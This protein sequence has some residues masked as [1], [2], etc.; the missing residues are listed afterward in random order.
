MAKITNTRNLS[1]TVAKALAYDDYS[2]GD[3]D[4]TVTGL[5]NPKQYTVLRKQ[6]DEEIVKDVADLAFSAFGSALHTL[7]ENAAQPWVNHLKKLFNDKLA[8]GDYTVDQDFIEQLEALLLRADDFQR[9]T[10]IRAEER[11]FAKI[12]VDGK[13]YVISGQFD[14]VEGTRLS[15]HKVVPI[16]DA[17]F[18]NSYE[19]YQ[20]QLSMLV[21]IAKQN[22]IEI[23]ETY[24]NAFYRD[25]HLAKYEEDL[26]RS[27]SG[28]TKHPSAPTANIKFDIL[29]DKLI[30]EYIRE[31]I[32]YFESDTVPPCT[33]E[34]VWK[35]EDTWKVFNKPNLKRATRNFNDQ[36]EADAFL[37]AQRPK[38]KDAYIEFHPGQRKRCKNYCDAAPFCEQYQ[39]WLK[40]NNQL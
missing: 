12:D 10:G 14:L 3:S 20:Y 32:R 24:I 7:I 25:W 34:E 9:K 21:W 29:D 36:S 40:D 1:D 38:F 27:Y 39:S 2:A 11:L 30:E 28:N 23:T 35:T 22:N 37:A 4:Y 18:Q 26:Q 19:K 6:H 33:D 5:M 8:S 13:D 31:R 17:I 16:W 15:D